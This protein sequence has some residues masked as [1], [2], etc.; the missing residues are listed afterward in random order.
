MTPDEARATLRDRLE[1]RGRDFCTL[2]KSAIY[3]NTESPYLELLKNAGCTYDDLEELV[4]DEGLEDAL[5]RLFQDGVYLTCNEFKGREEIRRGGRIIPGGPSLVRNPN[6]RVHIRAHSGGSGGKSVPV[7][8]DLGF[9]RDRAANHAL[10]LEARGGFGWDHAI[11]GIPG[12]TDMVRILELA[13]MGL[14]PG[15]WFSQVDPSS[16]MLHPRYRWSSRVMRW[17]GRVYGERLPA[18]EYVPLSDPGRILDWLGERARAG[19]TVHIVTWASGAVR[20]AQEAGR[21]GTDLSHVRFSIGGEPITSTKLET[22]RRTGAI[23]VPRY[24]AMECGYVAYGCLK[25]SGPDDLHVFDDMQAVITAG[26]AGLSR[27][28]PPQALLLSSLRPRAPFILLNVSLG[29]QADF[30]EGSC[31]CALE[32]TGW[33]KRIRNVRSFEKLTA[34]GMTFLDTDII[35]VLERDLPSRFGGTL[36]DYQLAE[37]EDGDGRPRLRLVVHPSVGPLDPDLVKQAFLEAAGA[38]AGVE[39]VMSLQWRDAGFLEV[40]RKPPQL[41]PSGK[42]VHLLKSSR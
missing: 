24:L 9:V 21:S 15:K 12:N 38:G 13:A 17:A 16:P 41:A 29:D 32:K 4:R 10:V 3:G 14:A 20:I 6:A 19:R 23:A 30:G 37:E 42:I 40:E 31:G 39:R 8:I 35:R 33:T 1:N 25:P 11:W 5:S 2:M 28:L 18:P 7:L 34:G 22:I 26:A 36:F 27:G